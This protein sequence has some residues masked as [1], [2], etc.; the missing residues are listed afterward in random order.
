MRFGWEA[1]IPK[2]LD[3]VRAALED[4][5]HPLRWQPGLVRI[6]P[7][8]GVPGREGAVA[9]YVFDLDGTPFVLTETVLADRLPEE[10]TTSYRGRGMRHEVTLSLA[11]DG[12][13]HTTLR[14]VHDGHLV[15][16]HRL[17]AL[18]MRRAF[19]QRWRVEFTALCNYLTQART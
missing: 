17:L 3:E 6:D 16:L 10:R 15:G 13:E 7:Q 4:P 19:R 8:E 18:P 12:P 14:A 11:A 1:D 5:A 9:R 2:P